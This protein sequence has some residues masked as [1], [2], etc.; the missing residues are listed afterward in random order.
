MQSGAAIRLRS[1]VERKRLAGL[2]ALARSGSGIATGLYS[3]DAT[4]HLYRHLADLADGILQAGWPVIV[5]ATFSAR[6]QR[7]LFRKLADAR[8]VDFRILDFALAEATLRERIRQRAQQ[9]GDASEA[10]LAVLQHQLETQEPLAPDE[11]GAV[12][13]LDDTA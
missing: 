7:D 12:V 11:L 10:D 2:D 13:A 8:G 1:D 5:D 3:A 4:R 9:G 6:W